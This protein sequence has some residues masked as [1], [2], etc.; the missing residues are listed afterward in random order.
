MRGDVDT[1]EISYNQTSSPDIEAS[2]VDPK[3]AG[4]EFDIPSESDIEEAAEV[5]EEGLAWS[6]LDGNYEVVVQGAEEEGEEED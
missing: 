1:N 2:Y 4:G 5:P 6:Y 3:E